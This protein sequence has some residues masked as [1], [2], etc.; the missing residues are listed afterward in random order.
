MNYLQRWERSQCVRIESQVSVVWYRRVTGDWS[1]V[2]RVVLP[3]H[4]PR[5]TWPSP[6]R[7]TSANYALISN[8][9]IN[10]RNA[11]QPM[12]TQELCERI[13]VQHME[14]KLNRGER[15]TLGDAMETINEDCVCVLYTT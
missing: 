15:V 9:R 2:G 7:P 6:S 14:A 13:Q 10:V 8:R 1:E 12:N 3:I 11:Q 4:T 5:P